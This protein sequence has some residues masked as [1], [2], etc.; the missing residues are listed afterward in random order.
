[1]ANKYIDVGSICQ[2]LGCLYNDP[3]LLE[4]TDKYTFDKDDFPSDFHKI[5][6]QAIYNT[7]VAG[8]AKEMTLDVINSYLSGRPEQQAIYKVN[9]GDEF[10][11]TAAEIANS[12]TFDYHYRRMKKF[13]LLRTYD[14]LGIDLKWYLNEDDLDVTKD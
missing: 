9:R 7:Y 14:R 2:V 3:S 12:F 8:N 13:S 11:L 6:F 5:A 1:M 10:L 4:K